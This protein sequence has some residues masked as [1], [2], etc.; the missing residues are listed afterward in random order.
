MQIQLGGGVKFGMEDRQSRAV[1]GNPDL[2]MLSHTCQTMASLE[3][4]SGVVCPEIH[5]IFGTPPV[6]K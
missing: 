2:T 1:Q 4:E 5:K 6:K 3:V